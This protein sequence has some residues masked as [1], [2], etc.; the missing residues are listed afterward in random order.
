MT[1]PI[2]LNNL[3]SLSNQTTAI[4]TINNNNSSIETA[5]GSALYTSGDTM[6]GT[7]NM[8]SN[9]I[10]NLPAPS[11][12]DSP[13][14]LID[15][16]SNPTIE[17]PPVGTSGAVVPLLNTANTWSALQTFSSG[18][19]APNVAA[20]NVANTWTATQTFD[21]ATYSALFTAGSVG[22]GTS[23][24]TVQ[25]EID[26]PNAVANPTSA[27][28]TFVKFLTGSSSNPITTAHPSVAISRYEQISS[29]TQ[30]GENPGLLVEVYGNNSTNHATQVNAQVILAQQNGKGDCVASWSYATQNSTQTSN[31]AYGTFTVAQVNLAGQPGYACNAVAYNNTGNLTDYY[32]SGGTVLSAFDAQPSGQATV[33]FHVDV[34]LTGSGGSGN[35]FDVGLLI[36]PNMVR[37]YSI[38]D[39]SSSTNIMLATGTHTNGIN[40]SNATFSGNTFSSPGFAVA[41]TGA[42]T[43]TGTSTTF[44]TQGACTTGSGTPTL[45]ANLPGGNAGVD[46]WLVVV[47]NGTTCYIPC[48]G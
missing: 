48:F 31:T 8:N 7:L 20:T 36:E 30:G 47:I 10:I 45:S 26:S 27:N 33:A 41:S 4:T 43:L 14:R 9:Q 2:T 39:A 18:I 5:F 28:A 29:N 12:V 46:T 19:S 23:T 22:I 40:L 38:Y 15:V 44:A 6:L 25:L 35:Q 37:S 34:P 1:V 21:N 42:V 17:V 3:T 32:L 16:T 11:T 13:A 24:P